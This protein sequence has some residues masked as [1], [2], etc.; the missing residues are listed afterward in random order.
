MVVRNW[1]SLILNSQ[2]IGRGG[3]AL[4]EARMI[5]AKPENIEAFTAEG[6]W[7][8]STI[9][10]MF[11]ARVSELGDTE[12]VIDPINRDAIFGGEPFKGYGAS[13]QFHNNCEF[14][15]EGKTK[16]K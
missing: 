6:W 12:A 10:D 1:H 9:D 14:R 11:R 13:K 5:L 8:T 2:N 4:G 16:I 7:G 15:D 3:T